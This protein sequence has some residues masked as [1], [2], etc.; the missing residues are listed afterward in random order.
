MPLMSFSDSLGKLTLSI[1]PSAANNWYDGTYN[2]PQVTRVLP[3]FIDFDTY[4]YFSNLASINYVGAAIHIFDAA[5]RARSNSLRVYYD[6]GN[7]LFRLLTAPTSAIGPINFTSGRG[8]MRLVKRASDLFV[9]Y[10]DADFAS[11]PANDIA[12]DFSV[13]GAGVFAPYINNVVLGWGAIDTRASGWTAVKFQDFNF[14]T[15]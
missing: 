5:S 11:K 13:K 1:T 7:W 6:S 3:A 14:R 9:F 15:L 8:W 4:V 12:W 2:T 10:K